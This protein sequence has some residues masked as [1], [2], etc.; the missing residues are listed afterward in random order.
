M[1]DTLTYRY[2]HKAGSKTVC[3]VLHGGGPEGIETPFIASIINALSNKSASVFG[4]NFPYCERREE[5]SSGPELAE[6]TAALNEV[7]EFLRS[8]GYTK[9]IIVAKS[10]GGIVTSYW[11][12]QCPASDIEVVILGY[13]IGNVKTPALRNNLRLVIQGENDRFGSAQAVQS[14]LARNDVKAEVIEVPNADHSYRNEQ[15]E[16]AYQEQ[17]VK[18][19]SDKLKTP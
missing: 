1:L 3:L 17:T 18:L 13:V 10:L 15:K 12:S 8:D 7:V 5:Q 14:E 2:Y 9:I 19:L 16:P 4:F 11:L 6:E